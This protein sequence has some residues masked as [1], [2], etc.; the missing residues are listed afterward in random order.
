[1]FSLLPSLPFF[2]FLSDYLDNVSLYK[3]SLEFPDMTVH[4]SFF[5]L[6]LP[7]KKQGDTFNVISEKGFAAPENQLKLTLQER[8]HEM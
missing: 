5:L 6:N 8:V 3:W 7:T 2:F 1:P 4:C